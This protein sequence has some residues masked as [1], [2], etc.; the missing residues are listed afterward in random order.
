MDHFVV[1]ERKRPKKRTSEKKEAA[2]PIIG[3][4][5]P[6]S[7]AKKTED[8]E[9]K[10]KRRGKKSRE[11]R[12]AEKSEDGENV[13]D[14]EL[15]GGDT[16]QYV[17]TKAH[18]Q[19]KVLEWME[20]KDVESGKGKKITKDQEPQE[21]SNGGIERYQKAGLL[22][23][24]NGKET[25]REDLDSNDTKL[26]GVEN[27]ATEGDHPAVNIS[28]E[29]RNGHNEDEDDFHNSKSKIYYAELEERLRKK[30][31]NRRRNKKAGKA[32]RQA[33][34]NKTLNKKQFVK[35]EWLFKQKTG[36]KL[37]TALKVLILCILL[38][39]LTCV[40]LVILEREGV[41]VDSQDY[42][43]QTLSSCLLCVRFY[44]R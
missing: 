6:G 3:K 43:R 21:S 13:T 11:S 41:L 39:L 35:D 29:E 42:L 31:A 4:E 24:K 8:K 18:R 38:G 40:A 23:Y 27:K 37:W 19:L 14:G 1:V 2:P 44:S 28:S 5:V 25:M 12:S 34:A 30:R 7:V 32:R 17:Q 36:S 9:K 20:E 26:N 22:E 16:D 15:G 33:T 10:R